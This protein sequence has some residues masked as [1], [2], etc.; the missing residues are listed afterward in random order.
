MFYVRLAPRALTARVDELQV[1]FGEI[2]RR[3]RLAAGLSQERL[4]ELAGLHFTTVSLV[5]RG[6]M[7]PTLV[8]VR[9][10]ADGLGCTMTELVAELEQESA[11][12]PK[13]KK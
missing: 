10:L 8:V 6:K 13:R 1:K 12:R 11:P 3:R 9:K 7:V 5:E 4:G 2:V